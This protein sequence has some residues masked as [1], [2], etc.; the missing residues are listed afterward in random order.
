MANTNTI[1]A[2]I[3]NGH[4]VS[5][6][7]TKDVVKKNDGV[8]KEMFLQ[9]LVAEMQYQ[10]PL[11]PTTN[12]EYV[13]ELAS[14]SQIEAIQAVQEQMNTIQANS[15]VG[16]Y[17]IINH[18]SSSSGETTEVTGKVDFVVNDGDDGIKMSVNGNL[19]S[20]D[21]LDTVIDE[22]YYDAIMTVSTFSDM[23]G[24]VPDSNQLTAQDKEM[25]NNLLALYDAMTAYQKSYVSVDDLNTL[26]DAANKISSLEEA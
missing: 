13:S 6:T 10:D 2:D 24:K 12:T 16:R 9:L 1:V 15:L 23:V 7:N 3:Q 17:V 26:K 11:E 14:F 4:V 18:Y 19:Y 25:I 21:E 22:D 8:D 5:N 20:I